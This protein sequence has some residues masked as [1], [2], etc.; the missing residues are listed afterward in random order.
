MVTGVQEVLDR[1]I[2]RGVDLVG[3]GGGTGPASSMETL[4]PH[5]WP[6]GS[7]GSRTALPAIR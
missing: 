1:V 3:G 4:D 2:E 5:Y 7:S 6:T